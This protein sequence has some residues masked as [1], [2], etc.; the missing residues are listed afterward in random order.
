[1]LADSSLDTYDLQSTGTTG[2]SFF[3]MNH[4][5]LALDSLGEE[6]EDV[7]DDEVDDDDDDDGDA[8]SSSPSIPDDV[9]PIPLSA[10]LIC[11]R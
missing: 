7:F 6:D 8:L 5:D 9:G 1:V 4:D 3:Q 11:S 2:D 10:S